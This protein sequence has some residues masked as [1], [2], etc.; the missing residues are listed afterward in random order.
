MAD[1]VAAIRA[2]LAGNGPHRWESIGAS[3]AGGFTSALGRLWLADGTSVA[4]KRPSPDP[5]TSAIARALDLYGREG[6]FYRHLAERVAGHGIAV[7][8]LLLSED[9]SLVLDWIDAAQPASQLQGWTAAQATQAVTALAKL[10]VAF[11]DDDADLTGPPI[12]LPRWDDPGYGEMVGAAFH[13]QWPQVRQTGPVTSAPQLSKIGDLI[14]AARERLVGWLA[15]P[16]ATLLHG[17]FRIDNLLFAGPSADSP[18]VLL[19]WQLSG[20]GRPALDLAYFLVQGAAPNERRAAE[21]ALI[22]HYRETLAAAGG[23]S[24]LTGF[25]E[26]YRLAAAY[27]LVYPVCAWGMVGNDPAKRELVL[28]LLERLAAAA[29]EWHLGDAVEAFLAAA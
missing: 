18:V 14:P 4:V 23:E 21:T 27:C 17:D 7:P 8:A 12:Q 10:H 25:D 24:L 16:P 26:D 1:R 20:V 19:D 3:G 29:E 11:A 15:R 9:E 5:Q 28:V 6:R 22:A 13:A 2:A